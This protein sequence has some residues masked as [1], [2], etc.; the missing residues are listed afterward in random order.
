MRN[1]PTAL[2]G[3]VSEVH[4]PSLFPA[5][6]VYDLTVVEERNIA[7][8]VGVASFNASSR[9]SWLSIT[10]SV[11]IAAARISSAAHGARRSRGITRTPDKN[12]CGCADAD[13]T[14]NRTGARRRGTRDG[15]ADSRRWFKIKYSIPGNHPSTTVYA[16]YHSL[17]HAE[18]KNT[19]ARIVHVR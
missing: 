16:S 1:E 8:L 14:R 15:I 5:I 11:P 17:R 7:S 18:S 10:T 9:R 3:D 2:R 4:R 19:Y 12:T 13:T 6:D